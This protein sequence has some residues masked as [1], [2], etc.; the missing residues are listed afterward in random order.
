MNVVNLYI[1]DEG[2][3][4]HLTKQKLQSFYLAPG[5]L[6]RW[7]GDP[8]IVEST[9]LRSIATLERR[10]RHDLGLKYPDFFL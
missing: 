10:Q 3:W 5:F 1:D 6:T 7:Q 8:Q 9:L 2:Q 4:W